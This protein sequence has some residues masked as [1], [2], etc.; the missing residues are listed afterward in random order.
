L[1]EKPLAE[2][3]LEDQVNQA[4][5][6][7]YNP[8]ANPSPAAS[9]VVWPFGQ[10]GSPRPIS[11]E[12]VRRVFE[13]RRTRQQ[14]FPAKLF[15]DPAW[16]ML[17]QLYAAHLESQRMSITRLTRTCAIPATTVLRRLA[18]LT[19]AGL[20]TRTEDPFDSRRVYVALSFSGAEAM[21]RCFAASGLAA[22][23][24]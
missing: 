22:I 24:L 3:E 18:T 4:A 23:L 16:D 6:K 5:V 14:S 15:A 1:P 11:A 7:A 20:V 17:L 19:E 13:L 21:D 8:G 10:F 9:N 12:I 2:W